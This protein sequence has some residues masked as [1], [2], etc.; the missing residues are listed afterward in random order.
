[1]KKLVYVLI[2]VVLAGAPVAKVPSAF[3]CFRHIP[4]TCHGW[5][6]VPRPLIPLR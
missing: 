6:T 4:K 3:G 2:V 5:T 1:M